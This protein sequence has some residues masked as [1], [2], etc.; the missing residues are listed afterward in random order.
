MEMQGILNEEYSLENIGW[1]W[2]CNRPFRTRIQG[3]F[4]LKMTLSLY[5][6]TS[7]LMSS[8]TDIYSIYVMVMEDTYKL[9]QMEF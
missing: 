5:D 7:I 3:P 1:E 4:H 8:E 6:K 2:A 9:N